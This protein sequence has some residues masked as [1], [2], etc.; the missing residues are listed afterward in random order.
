MLKTYT[1]KSRIFQK[2]YERRQRRRQRRK[3]LFS[4][5]AFVAFVIIIFIIGRWGGREIGKKINEIK[6]PVVYS[7]FITE[8]AYDNELDPYLVNA[9]IKQESN[10]IAD[11][12]SDYAGGLMQLTEVTANEYAKKLGLSEYNY[13]DPETNIKI[14]CFVLASLIDKYDNVD[15]ALAAY[16]AGV[17]NVDGWL[18]NPDYSSDGKT[19]YYIPFSETRHY[20]K[21]VNQYIEIYKNQAVIQP[22]YRKDE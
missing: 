6:Y 2:R 15:T 7:E 21:K 13:M 4:L 5:I 8:Y 12:R 10:F 14:G 16:N 19:L 3:K 1:S 17:G 11:A 9:L 22:E 18:K 20:V